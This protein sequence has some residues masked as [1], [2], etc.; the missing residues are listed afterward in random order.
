MALNTLHHTVC[1]QFI[2]LLFKFSLLK[3]S[4]V[5]KEIYL[6]SSNSNRVRSTIFIPDRESRKDYYIPSFIGSEARKWC[7]ES[8][9]SMLAV[10]AGHAEGIL[11]PVFDRITTLNQGK[12]VSRSLTRCL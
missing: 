5:S 7:Q 1:F 4:T 6:L 2:D 12:D 10:K 8:V 11:L 3:F 9:S